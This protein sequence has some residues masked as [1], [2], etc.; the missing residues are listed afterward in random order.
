MQTTDYLAAASNQYSF[1]HQNGCFNK[2]KRK[3]N[4]R[5]RQSYSHAQLCIRLC[6][7]TAI[8]RDNSAAHKQLIAQ[9]VSKLSQLEM[10]NVK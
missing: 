8:Q 3:K 2:K 10:D 4:K 9:Q 6:V 1:I 7:A 5:L